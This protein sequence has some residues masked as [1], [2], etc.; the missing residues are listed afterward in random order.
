MKSIF[1][2]ASMKIRE[3]LSNDE[4]FNERIPEYDRSTANKENFLG[5]KWIHDMDVI[6]VTLKPW[7]GKKITKRTI[8][9][10][11]ASQYDPLGFLVPSMVP[12]KLF[13]QYLWKENKSWDKVLNEDDEQQWNALIKEWSTNVID[14]PKFAIT[15]SLQTEIHVFTDASNVAY[16]TAMYVLRQGNQGTKSNSFLIY[17]KFR[18]ALIKGISIPRLEL[19]SILIGNYTKLLPRFVQNRVEEIREAKFAFRY[20]RSEQNPV[21][22]A[23]K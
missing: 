6:R 14:V 21:D 20:I 16:F 5:L 15:N 8:I 11:V 2:E 22:I 1:E 4:E 7:V 18:I 10:F 19:L 9:Q 17:A 23:T 3:F 12:F 13:I